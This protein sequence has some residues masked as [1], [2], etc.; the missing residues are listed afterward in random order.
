MCSSD[1]TTGNSVIVNNGTDRVRRYNSAGVYQ[2]SYST[3]SLAAAAAGKGDNIYVSAGTYDEQIN[4]TVENVSFIGENKN[5]TIIKPSSGSG[6]IVNLNISG[7][8]ISNFT[9]D[10]SANSS[11]NQGIECVNS[12]HLANPV[13][14]ENNIIKGFLTS[15]SGIYAYG[16][17]ITLTDNT[18][19]NYTTSGLYVTGRMK[20]VITNN[21][22]SA[23]GGFS[24]IGI[25]SF[26]GDLTI[27]N[28]TVSGN[29]SSGNGYGISIGVYSPG[30]GPFTLDCSENI[31]QD[32]VT[33]ISIAQFNNSYTANYSITH[34]NI[35]SISG[36]SKGIYIMRASGA[37]GSTLNIT[38]NLI[39]VL[40]GGILFDND[41]CN[42]FT[43][44]TRPT[45]TNNSIIVPATSANTGGVVSRYAT[46]PSF[47][48]FDISNN[49]W[50]NSTA[51]NL[52]RANSPA[53]ITDA[54]DNTAVITNT[55]SQSGLSM[56]GT[57][58]NIFKFSPALSSAPSV[59]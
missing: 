25:N 53:S 51:P 59:P 37:A 43:A 52:P 38:S 6:I 33:G 3:I 49:W 40:A 22:L 14:I 28:N 2:A 16:Y 7:N 10:A 47:G 30:T 45:V 54:V 50:G 20:T 8:S 56:T 21:T 46:V 1:L 19:Q 12:N 55:G 41:S 23:S 58:G 4:C 18:I 31:L 13:K 39:S 57:G 15:G 32:N 11:I 48:Y 29:N 35:T 24:G 44:A 26:E 42:S 5:T 17:N 9:L 27:S 34:N 36:G